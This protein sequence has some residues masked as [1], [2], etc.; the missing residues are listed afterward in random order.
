MRAEG[1][2]GESLAE[3][4]LK[5]KGYKIIGR[6]EKLMGIEVD[7]IATAPDGDV[8]FIEVKS[9]TTYSYGYALEAVTPAKSQ[10]TKDLLI[11]THKFIVFTTRRFASTLSQFRAT[12]SNISKTSAVKTEKSNIIIYN[13][14]KT[15]LISF[16]KIFPL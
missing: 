6:N 1:I 16:A 8:C 12:T 14:F 3:G 10:D 4:Y 15:R 11:F 9:R 7:L 13:Y 2:R 5:S